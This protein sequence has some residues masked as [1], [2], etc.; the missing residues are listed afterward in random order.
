MNNEFDEVDKILFKQISEKTREIV[1]KFK[2]KTAQELI[3][4]C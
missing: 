3:D 2:C 4:Q 1:R